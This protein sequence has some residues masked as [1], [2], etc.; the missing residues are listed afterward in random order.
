ML[1]VSSLVLLYFSTFLAAVTCGLPSSKVTP[2]VPK[3]IGG[4]PTDIAI[5]PHQLSLR[6][7]DFHVCGASIISEFWALSATSCIDFGPDPSLI[8]LLGGVTNKS[9]ENDAFIRK[10]VDYFYHPDFDRTTKAFDVAILKV[11]SPFP[12][13]KFFPIRLATT[14]LVIPDQ[15]EVAIAG[16]G[17]IDGGQVPDILHSLNLEIFNLEVCNVA[18]NGKIHER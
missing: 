2:Q 16:W 1:S 12:V 17:I 3:L 7:F 13:E 11:E 15:Y 14:Q 9:N 6:T 4:E 5:F 10:V 8:T 18:W